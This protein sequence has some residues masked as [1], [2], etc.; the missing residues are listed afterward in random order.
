MVLRVGVCRWCCCVVVMAGGGGQLRVNEEGDCEA[1]T[2]ARPRL[3]TTP[4]SLPKTQR[5][6]LAR[7]GP[8]RPTPHTWAW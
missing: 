3:D 2:A 8:T 4:T 5:Q 6:I 7:P 1:G